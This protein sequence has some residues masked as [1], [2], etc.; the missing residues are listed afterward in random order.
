MNDGGIPGTAR[1]DVCTFALLVDGQDVGG[2][3]HVLNIEVTREL[4]RIPTALIELRD[5]DPAGPGFPVSEG[6]VFVPGKEIEIQ[7]GYQ[8]DNE[9]VFKGTVVK[10]AIRVRKNQSQLV[11]E[12]RHACFK[13]ACDPAFRHFEG[14][15]DSEVMEELIAGHGLQHEVTQT[16]AVLEQLVQFDSCDWDYLLCRAEANGMV[17]LAEDAKLKV[18]PPDLSSDPVLRLQYGSTLIDLDLEI[19]ARVQNSAVQ[20]QSWSAADQA[21]TQ[22]DG[23]EKTLPAG[24]NL[25]ASDLADVS[26]GDT[27]LLRHTGALGSQELQAW[28]DGRLLRQRLAKLRGRARCQGSALLK[29]GAVVE[30]AGAGERVNGKLLISGVRHSVSKGNWETDVQLGLSPA[31]YATLQ[32]VHRMPAAGLLPAAQGLQIGVVTALEG[33]PAHEERI[34][35]RLPFASNS[36]E[37]VWARIACLDA[38][39]ERGTFFRPEVGNEVVLGFFDGDPRH[40]VVLGMLHSSANPPPEPVSDANDLKGY[41]SRERMRLQFDDGKKIALFET[42]AG[43]SITLSEQDK[44]IKIEDQHG[45][46][47]LMDNQGITINSSKDLVLKAAKDVK[48]EGGTNVDIKASVGLTAAGNASAEISGASTTIKGSA[49]VKIQGGIVQIN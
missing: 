32:K 48:L 34:A 15:R 1:A 9:A 12:C 23:A 31:P 7:L 21:L 11:V 33:D 46:S 43:N 6:D 26:G 5:G 25:S 42:P 40:P 17:V 13:L 16:G 49:L 44:H 30:L 47:I 29:P 2:R 4:N 45:N 28:A 10:H 8:S 3:F 37:G 35:V 38:G 36:S 19:D 39:K 18:M 41:V 27:E 14:K 24:G 20:A 22:A